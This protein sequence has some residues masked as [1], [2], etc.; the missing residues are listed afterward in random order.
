[1]KVLTSSRSRREHTRR[2]HTHPDG[3]EKIPNIMIVIIIMISIRLIYIF[4]LFFWTLNKHYKKRKCLIGVVV[5]VAVFIMW[6][7][8][9]GNIV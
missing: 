7:S 1:M 6:R 4:I 2:E 5:L 8:D 3:Q 9:C